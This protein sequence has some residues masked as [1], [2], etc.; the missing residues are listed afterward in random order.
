MTMIPLTPELFPNRPVYWMD[1]VG[2]VIII[3]EFAFCCECDCES[4]KDLQEIFVRIYEKP[5]T[6]PDDPD[7]M[8]LKTGTVAKRNFKGENS[9][10]HI[11]NF[12]VKFVKDE[13]YRKDFMITS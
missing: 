3:G 11:R 7:E 4:E 12:I 5:D 10:V 2:P 13:A 8:I 1:D 6:L 9:T